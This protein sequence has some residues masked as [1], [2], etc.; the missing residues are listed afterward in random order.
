MWLE[1]KEQ[2][3][4]ELRGDAKALRFCG[5]RNNLKFGFHFECTRKVLN[6]KFIV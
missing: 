3:G 6:E 5:L 2:V 1:V 4:N